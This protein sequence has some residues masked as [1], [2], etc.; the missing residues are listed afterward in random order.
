MRE[1][2]ESLTPQQR[3]T[4]IDLVSELAKLA[5]QELTQAV[6]KLPVSTQETILCLAAIAFSGIVLRHSAARLAAALALVTPP[7]PRAN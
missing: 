6:A 2:F 1:W 3:R 5:G 4:W 7:D